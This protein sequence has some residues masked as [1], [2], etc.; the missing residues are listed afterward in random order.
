[1]SVEGRPAGSFYLPKTVQF[2]AFTRVAV[3]ANAVPYASRGWCFTETCLSQLTKPYD[4]SLDLGALPEKGAS[5]AVIKA[6]CTRGSRPPPRLP[7]EFEEELQNM[8]FRED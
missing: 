7:K 3:A 6:A 1:M 5:W 2:S 4:M 8:T